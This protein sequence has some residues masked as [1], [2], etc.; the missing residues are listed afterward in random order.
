V[1]S[2]LSVLKPN[3]WIHNSLS[4]HWVLGMEP[5]VSLYN[6]AVNPA[7]QFLNNRYYFFH[8]AWSVLFQYLLSS[9]V[10]DEMS[11]INFTHY[12]LYAL[13][14]TSFGY[15]LD[16]TLSLSFGNFTILCSGVY[17][18]VF[19]MRRVCLTLGNFKLM[20]YIYVWKL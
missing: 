9:I 5:R 18:F 10:S 12:P 3:N 4:L 17:F 11:V 2:L 6:W 14:G 7:P 16:L 15:F 20:S 13:V 19:V 1:F 8:L